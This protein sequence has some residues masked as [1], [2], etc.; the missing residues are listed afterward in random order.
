[1]GLREK[2]KSRRAEQVLDA[3]DA[4]FRDQG[5]E[6][7]KIEEIAEAA[8]VA[9]ATVYNYFKTKPNLLME[10]A[11]RHLR[12]ALPERRDFIRNLPED[13]VEGIIA[14]ERLLAEQ[15][16]RHLT[17]ECWRIVLAAQYVEA[18]GV[19]HLTARRLDLAIRR[20]YLSMLTTYQRRGRIRADVDLPVLSD[21]LIG[22]GTAALGHL[23]TSTDTPSGPLGDLAIDHIHLLLKAVVVPVA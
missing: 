2:H 12:A 9:S 13:P 6:E 16:V 23:V 20:Q 10:I 18:G 3:A 19:A 5:Y 21:L 14:F 1:M 15:A 11:L 17:P 4:L 8:S 22:I 7:T